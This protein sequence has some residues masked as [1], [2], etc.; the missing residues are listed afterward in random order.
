MTKTDKGW[1]YTTDLPRGKH[2]YKYIVDSS[3]IVDPDNKIQEYDGVGN[4]NSVIM[5]K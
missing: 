2:H 4:I 5:V 1:I 3:W